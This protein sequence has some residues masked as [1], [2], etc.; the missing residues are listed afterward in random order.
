[1]ASAR[2]DL[3]QPDLPDQAEALAGLTSRLTLSTAFSVVDAAFQ[4][5][6]DGEGGPRRSSSS[7]SLSAMVV[8]PHRGH[9]PAE[10]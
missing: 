7:S 2:V 4:R 1:M 9:R 5:A 10:A 6:A 3:P 8:A